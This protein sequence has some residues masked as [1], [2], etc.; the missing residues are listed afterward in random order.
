MLG[1][2]MEWAQAEKWIGY[3]GGAWKTRGAKCLPTHRE[4]HGPLHNDPY[5]GFRVIVETK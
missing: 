5:G 1:N 3:R 2:A 4:G